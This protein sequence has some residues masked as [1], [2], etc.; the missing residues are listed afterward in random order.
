MFWGGSPRDIL[1]INVRVAVSLM[2]I[3]CQFVLM[4]ATLL[5]LPPCR[6]WFKYVYN[7][8]AQSKLA[9]VAYN[10]YVMHLT[11]VGH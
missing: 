2:I 10:R 9:M 3:H 1:D 4:Q 5:E 7:S 11:D 8:S 6:C